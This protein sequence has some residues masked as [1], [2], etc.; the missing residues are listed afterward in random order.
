M[1]AVDARLVGVA[2]RVPHPSWPE[3]RD[4]A[5]SSVVAS[6]A[7]RKSSVVDVCGSFASRIREREIERTKEKKER[8]VVRKFGRP[9]I[10]IRQEGGEW[11]VRGEI[12]DR[13]IERERYRKPV[14]AC[15]DRARSSIG[16]NCQNRSGETERNERAFFVRSE[17][18]RERKRKWKREQEQ[19]RRLERIDEAR[20]LRARGALARRETTRTR[21]S[22]KSILACT[23]VT[24]RRIVV[25][26][27]STGILVGRSGG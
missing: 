24:V 1:G 22:V 14:V 11:K 18:E 6:A 12:A 26:S 9:G 16:P 7:I 10:I 13:K 5:T 27:P 25:A 2:T 4:E 3:Q 17:R 15:R 21:S 8:A 23:P 19:E 20:D